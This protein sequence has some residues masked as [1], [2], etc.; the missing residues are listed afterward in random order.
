MDLTS[1]LKARVQLSK[2]SDDMALVPC[3]CI[4]VVKRVSF[5]GQA[6]RDY[7]RERSVLNVD[8][9]ELLRVDAYDSTLLR[10]ARLV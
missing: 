8:Y 7:R 3:P 4:H 1:Q 10:R 5:A 6:K 2:V 9:I